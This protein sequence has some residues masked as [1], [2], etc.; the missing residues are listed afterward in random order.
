MFNGFASPAEAAAGSNFC[1]QRPH[2]ASLFASRLSSTRFF[3]P[4][5][6]QTTTCIKTPLSLQFD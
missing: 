3:A 1:P 5:F 6:P 4:Q 2:F